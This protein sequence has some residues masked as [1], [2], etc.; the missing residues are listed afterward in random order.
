MPVADEQSFVDLAHRC[1]ERGQRRDAEAGSYYVW[2]PSR[3]VELWAQVEGDQL[4]G[5]NPHFAGPSRMTVAV[6]HRLS[7]EG[8]TSLEAMF[9]AWADP[10]EPAEPESGSFP[11]VFDA[12]D[13]GLVEL[14]ALPAVAQLQLA[15][16][17]H[18]LEWFADDAA[19]DASQ[20]EEPRF[21]PE[22]FFPIGLF[23]DGPPAPDGLGYGHLVEGG[24]RANDETGSSFWA[25]RVQTLGGEMDVVADPAFVDGEPPT[26][27]VLRFGGWLSGRLHL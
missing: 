27:A 19:F 18:E 26:G 14:P 3:G 21:A 16:F 5:L 17:A 24:L 6:T 2:E 1:V 11:F 25:G 20:P 13:A 12:A 22:S 10:Q 15:V 9:H 8:Y 7:G 23:G 4:V